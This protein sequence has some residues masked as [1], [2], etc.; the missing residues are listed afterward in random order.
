M[1]NN[2]TDDY[3][4]VSNAKFYADSYMN[5]LKYVKQARSW[6]A[7]IDGIWQFDSQQPIRA[8][9][10]CTSRMI[11]KASNLLVESTDKLR[12]KNHE[13]DFNHAQLLVKH[14]KTSQK[15]NRI[16][17]MVKLA[18]SDER[19]S[20]GIEDL[21]KN[22]NL[23]AVKNGVIQLDDLKF[24]EALPEDLL[25][26][27][28]GTEFSKSLNKCE[29]NRW[30][31][32]LNVTQPDPEVRTW[33]KRFA[34]YCLTGSIDEQFMAIFIGSG[35]NGKSV[36]VETI[37]RVLG[38]YAT[39]AQFDTFCERK[40]EAVRN[41]IA[42][43][44]NMR[45]VVANEGN[46]GARL[47]ESMIKQLTGGDEITARHLYQDYFTFTPKFK[48]ILVTNHK[49]VINGADHG[50]WRRIV[51]VP[52]KV[53][54]PPDKC[55]KKLLCKLDLERAGILNWMLEGL[56][57]YYEHG[58]ELPKS[59]V[60]AN[61]EYKKDSDLVGLWIEDCCYEGETCRVTSNNLYESYQK[62]ATGNGHRVM[63]AK[64]LGD[65]LTERG[66][67]KT[68]TNSH[69]GWIGLGLKAVNY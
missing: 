17:A 43:L 50:I 58:L 25:T 11:L 6:I 66:F 49:P 48:I 60:D 13:S 26:K 52:W 45:L 47:D 22:D 55:D 35:A 34:G 5:E 61:A 1:E 36:F 38:T 53:T 19:M 4:D 2:F 41:D 8:A 33:L 15:F 59:L 16:V 23:F 44:N 7:F 68:R 63:S 12:N 57:E 20:I 24:R 32:F 30:L 10:E 40:S 51:L 18:S 3:S 67:K 37:K 54:I 14:A 31:E 46:E 62:W 42:R 27:Q 21:D 69:R 28:A 39:Q 64:S 9:K 65:K 29:C 56:S